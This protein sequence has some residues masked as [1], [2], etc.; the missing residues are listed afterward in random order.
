MK[1]V[2]LIIGVLVTMAVLTIIVESLEF[3]I[4]KS[5]SG[6]TMEYLSNNQVEYFSIRN[7]TWILV[8]KAVYTFLSA[9]LA[10]WLG[11]KITK[12]LQKPYFITI[13]VLQGAA[14]LYAMLFSEF[15][16]TLPIF[17]WL[18]L[19]VLVLSG[20]SMGNHFCRHKREASENPEKK[21]NY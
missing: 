21:I 10:G 5:S 4:V 14:F 11:S 17:Y 9:V 6:K 12:Y 20:I 18:L 3:F 19:L 7:Q 13:V 16:N 8:L 15:K 2:R 1:I